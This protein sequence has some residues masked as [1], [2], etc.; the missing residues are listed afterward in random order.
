[1]LRYRQPRVR[2]R[3]PS[4]VAS[5]SED[6][7]EAARAYRKRLAM[8]VVLRE[9]SPPLRGKVLFFVRVNRGGPARS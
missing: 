4:L 5:F 8:L 1:M 9:T 2:R 6:L 3:Y 7:Q